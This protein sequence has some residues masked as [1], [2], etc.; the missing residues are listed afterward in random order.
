MSN[1][2]ATRRDFEAVSVVSNLYILRK[3]VVA[4]V[5]S[6]IGALMAM[7]H[8]RLVNHVATSP[9]DIQGSVLRRG[10]GSTGNIYVVVFSYM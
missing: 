4:S 8:F 6:G 5:R 1:T 9:D 3:S 2:S 7:G 10:L